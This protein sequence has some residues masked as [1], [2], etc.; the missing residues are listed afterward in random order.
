MAERAVKGT[1]LRAEDTR[2]TKNKDGKRGH[3]EETYRRK[4]REGLSK[5]E[6]RRKYIETHKSRLREQCKVQQSDDYKC[7]SGRL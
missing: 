3:M 7:P 2:E 4:K 6:N 5:C 1:D